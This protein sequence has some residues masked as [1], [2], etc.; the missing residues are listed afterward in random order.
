MLRITIDET[1]EAIAIRLDG[2]VTGPW[3][4]ELNKAWAEAAPRRGTKKVSLDLRNVTFMDEKGKLVLG[5]IH[6]ETAAEL[7]AGTPWTRF[8]AEEIVASSRE[9]R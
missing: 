8:L 4:A 2:R 6:A 3:A 7:I 1:S 9:I 5:A